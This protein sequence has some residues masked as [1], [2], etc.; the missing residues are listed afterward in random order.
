VR[1]PPHAETSPGQPID[2][3]RPLGAAVAFGRELRHEGLA[4][5]LGAAVDFARALTLVDVADRGQVRGAGE[6][7]FVRR[8]DDRVVYEED[9][10]QVRGETAGR[11]LAESA[12][13]GRG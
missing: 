9:I 1:E 5:D 6:A 4:V 3:R 12:V 11:Y 10:R 2:G 13:A 7:V 8:R